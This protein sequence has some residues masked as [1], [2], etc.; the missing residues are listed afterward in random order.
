MGLTSS[1]QRNKG[2]IAPMPQNFTRIMI[3][4]MSP[5]LQLHTIIE[6]QRIHQKRLQS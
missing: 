2:K 3:V 4:Q 1:V 6:H 5:K